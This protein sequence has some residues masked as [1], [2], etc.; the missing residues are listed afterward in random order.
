LDFDGGPVECAT[1]LRLQPIIKQLTTHYLNN[2]YSP[3]QLAQAVNEVIET[4]FGKAY[5]ETYANIHKQGTTGINLG[6]LVDNLD[7]VITADSNPKEI[8]EQLHVLSNFA[9]YHSVGREMGNINKVYYNTDVIKNDLAS[10]G[11][12]NAV[13]DIRDEL[14]TKVMGGKNMIETW[15]PENFPMS[16]SFYNIYEEMRDF[17]K[18]FMPYASTEARRHFGDQLRALLGKPR[19][20]EEQH[21]AAHKFVT[22]YLL[23]RPDSPI[24]K[25]FDKKYTTSLLNKKVNGVINENNI[26]R[27]LSKVKDQLLFENGGK[28]PDLVNNTFLSALDE[29]P[30]NF[31]PETDIVALKFNSGGKMTPFEINNL[32]DGFNDLFNHKDKEIRDLA[33]SLVWY[34]TISKG[35]SSG[36]DSF[37]DLIPLE[38]MPDINDYIN[39][40][41]KA[42][43]GVTYG[44]AESFIE[45][46]YYMDGLV[47]S[48]KQKQI[49]GESKGMVTIAIPNID[50]YPTYV[51]QNKKGEITLFKLYDVTEE[52]GVYSKYQLD[53]A[54]EVPNNSPLIAKGVPYKYIDLSNTRS[55]MDSIKS[56][57]QEVNEESQCVITSTPPTK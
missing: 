40:T 15:S 20:G 4:Q 43:L 44:F 26:A 49:V 1:V 30:D 48:I 56:T 38:Q 8:M 16:Q 34:S 25:W 19:L 45:N 39:Q 17:T 18:N 33:K 42:G 46:F 41:I 51:K 53:S 13:D 37:A 57:A 24:S 36:V 27:R 12:L 5:L 21:T 23:S 10:V 22:V 31:T 11:G 55:M 3:L 35:L 2:D 6:A 28:Y 29:H 52:G 47:T 9:H 50:E 14:A 32:I 7:K 54:M